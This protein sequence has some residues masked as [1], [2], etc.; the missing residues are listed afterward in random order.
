MPHLRE[1]G[2]TEY[3]D[4]A[5][6]KSVLVELLLRGRALSYSLRRGKGKDSRGR[7]IRGDVSEGTQQPVDHDDDIDRRLDCKDVEA[8]DL[9]GCVSSVFV[10][11]VTDFVTEYLEDEVADDG[12]IHPSPL[13]FPGLKRLGMRGV[14]SVPQHIITPFVLACT[15]LTH[16]DLSGTRVGPELLDALGDST[17]VHLTALSLGRCVRLTADSIVDFLIHGLPTRNLRHLSLYG[18]GTF[19]SPLSELHLRRLITEAPCFLSGAL[20]YLD[21]SSSPLTS[22]LLRLFS[23]QPSLRSLGLSYIPA[24]PLRVI[25]DFVLEKAPNVEVLAL[26][27]TSPELGLHVPWRQLSMSLHSTIINPLATAPFKFSLSPTPEVAPPPTRVRVIELGLGALNA[28]GAGAGNWRVIRSKGGRG[29]YVDSSSGWVNGELR[30]S[31]PGDHPIRKELE[32]LA[33]SN[34]NVSTGVGWHA[35]K[36]EVLHGHGMLGREDGLYGAVSF[37]Y[38]G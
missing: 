17:T 9:C 23:S 13:I 6:D 18:D 29:W 21:L 26:I 22:D 2:A 14:T 36:M 11:A 32:R 34:G 24:L 35:R 20:E 15:S 25:S 5:L 37:A 1:F 30:R 8:L 10:Q 19:I 16:L 12:S 4:G 38:Q 27:G 28:L 33:A 3:M 31:L 7:G